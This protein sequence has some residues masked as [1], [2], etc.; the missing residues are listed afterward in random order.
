M[1]G[2]PGVPSPFAHRPGCPLCSIVA[3]PY[4]RDGSDVS[5]LDVAASS[6]MDGGVGGASSSSAT[7]VVGYRT[8]SPVRRD[9]GSPVSS[10]SSSNTNRNN[11]I[12]YGGVPINSATHSSATNVIVYKDSNITAFIEKK[13]PVSSK[14][15][16]IIVLK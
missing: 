11:S 9:S 12:G 14:G 6:N 2:A 4:P 1:S 16:I 3:T 8:Y 7:S 10:N 15:H 13:F 5:A